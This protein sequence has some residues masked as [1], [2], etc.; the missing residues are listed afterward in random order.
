M[1][2]L[3]LFIKDDSRDSLAE[4]LVLATVSAINTINNGDDDD[5]YNE[6]DDDNDDDDNVIFTGVF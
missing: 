6:D 2:L 5:D 1:L 3:L 4:V